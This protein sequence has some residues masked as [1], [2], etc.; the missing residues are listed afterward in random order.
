MAEWLCALLITLGF[1]GLWA[2]G[3][4]REGSWIAPGAILGGCWLFM[5]ALPLLVVEHYPLFIESYLL[6]F[7]FVATGWSGA[8]LVARRL[9]HLRHA[10]RAPFR[11]TTALLRGLHSMYWLSFALGAAS[12]VML[13]KIAVAKYGV[14]GIFELAGKISGDRYNGEFDQPFVVTLLNMALS[15]SG[16]LGGFL[17]GSQKKKFFPNLLYLAWALPLQ[18]STTIQTTKASMM[19]TV[20]FFGAGLIAGIGLR[21]GEGKVR[22]WRLFFLILSLSAFAFLFTLVNSFIRYGLE[23]MD[24]LTELI[25]A[26]AGTSFGH[27]S[28]LGT[29]L[30]E[31]GLQKTGCALGSYSFA[32]LFQYIGI[33]ERKQGL[34]EISVY[35]QNGYF[36]NIYT[37]FRSL[38]EDFTLYGGLLFMFLFG[39]IA[40][41][42]WIL[43]TRGRVWAASLVVSWMSFAFISPITSVFTYNMNFGALFMFSSVVIVFSFLFREK[44]N[45]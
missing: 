32:G 15:L 43:L 39:C 25:G 23:N 10:P 13:Y 5:A 35:F 6:V 2:G 18:V 30:N 4:L 38:I 31:G 34:Y 7:L 22:F 14:T 45:A 8:A 41:L 29:W 20:V 17:L 28:V 37:G 42:F 3:Y 36:S 26:S 12:P 16:I 33:G 44:N 27:M 1:G 24:L 21:G 11:W 9:R 40:E 19:F